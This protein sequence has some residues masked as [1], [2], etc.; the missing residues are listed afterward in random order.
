MNAPSNTLN[1]YLNDIGNHDL[2]TKADEVELA[3][4]IR[5]GKEASER[6]EAGEYR[7]LQ[8]LKRLERSTKKRFAC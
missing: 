1:I 2:L 4:Q 7:D 6:M 3:E 5:L 8:E